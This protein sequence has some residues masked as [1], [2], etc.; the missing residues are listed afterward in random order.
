MGRPLSGVWRASWAKANRD[1]RPYKVRCHIEAWLT[2]SIRPRCS[3]GPVQCLVDR[4]LDICGVRHANF[5]SA[6]DQRKSGTGDGT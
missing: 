6:W 3:C 5:H 4:S 1:F 2:F